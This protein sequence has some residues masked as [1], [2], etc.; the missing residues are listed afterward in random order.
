MAM[1]DHPFENTYDL[2]N[3][4][5][6]K[7]EEAEEKMLRNNLG[8]AEEILLEMLKSILI[9]LTNLKVFIIILMEEIMEKVIIIIHLQIKSMKLN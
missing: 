6:L 8:R 9:V 5:L 7:L 3:D 1:S 2:S 4:Q